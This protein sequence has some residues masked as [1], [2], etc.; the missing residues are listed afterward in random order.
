MDSGKVAYDRT[1]LSTVFHEEATNFSDYKWCIFDAQKCTFLVGYPCQLC[2]QQPKWG[3]ARDVLLVYLYTV[4]PYVTAQHKTGLEAVWFPDPVN[5]VHCTETLPGRG[6]WASVAQYECVCV[7]MLCP[8][9]SL[10]TSET[11]SRTDRQTSRG[12]LPVCRSGL[13]CSST[14]WS[15]SHTELQGETPPSCT[16]LYLSDWNTHSVH[17]INVVITKRRQMQTF[18]TADSYC[19]LYLLLTIN[20]TTTNWLWH[21]PLPQFVFNKEDHFFGWLVLF[22]FY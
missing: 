1:G 10:H 18:I 4:S 14:E 9:G 3:T 13:Q 11:G 12:R 22:C 19:L 6:V 2:R 21:L 17:V 20:R 8:C 16:L 5:D 7:C 15:G